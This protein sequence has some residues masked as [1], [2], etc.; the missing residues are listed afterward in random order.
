MKYREV[1]ERLR[2]VGVVMS[3]SGAS[4]RLNHFGGTS[5]T[6]RFTDSLDDA[7]RVGLCMVRADG[8][9]PHAHNEILKR[10]PG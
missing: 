10:S 5:E 3:K 2:S 1:Q 8:S 6:A 4:L 9:P 7:L